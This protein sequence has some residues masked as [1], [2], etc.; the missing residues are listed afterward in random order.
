MEALKQAADYFINTDE[1]E[2]TLYEKR[3]KLHKHA[4]RVSKWVD[5]FSPNDI[6]ILQKEYQDLNSIVSHRSNKNHSKRKCKRKLNLSENFVGH[7]NKLSPDNL[8][9][10]S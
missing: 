10:K 2:K 5:M 7:R 4:L 3:V 8:M 6:S 1:S 9:A